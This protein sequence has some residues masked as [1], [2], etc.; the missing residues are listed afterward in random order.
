[1]PTDPYTQVYDALWTLLSGRADFT[2]LVKLGN[3]INYSGSEDPA[4]QVVQS[5]DLPECEM[6]VGTF[7]FDLFKTSSS[8]ESMQTY[9]LRITTGDTRLDVGLFPIQYEVLKA[10]AS[11]G[12]NLGLSFVQDI[13]VT[14]GVDS[15]DDDEMKRG[16]R[17]WVLRITIAVMMTFATSDLTA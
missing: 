13:N 10:L 12:N 14:G 3:R 11:T 16:K 15:L 6:R 2:A 8:T 5:A 1:M 7:E 17:G 9:E 4:K